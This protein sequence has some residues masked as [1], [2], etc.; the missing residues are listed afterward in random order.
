MSTPDL[1]RLLAAQDLCGRLR[2]LL[3]DEFAALREQQLD[4][5]D[6]LQLP[7]S[8]L[9]ADLSETVATHQALIA[10]G[11]QLPTDWLSAWEVFRTSMLEC[12]D[13]H[14]RN[15]LLIMR[16]REAIQ[17]ALSALVGDNGT[18]ASVDLYDRLGKVRRTA[19]RNAY[20]QA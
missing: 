1:D 8:Q 16:K 6:Q 19:R 20:S 11:E 14:R 2:L 10:R 17:G 4:R 12:R 13:L 18:S 7:K 3:D 9:L 15:E 5:F